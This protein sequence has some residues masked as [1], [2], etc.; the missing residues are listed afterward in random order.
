MDGLLPCDSLN[1]I[2]MMGAIVN[3]LF[4]NSKRMEAAK[5]CTH[6]QYAAGE[7]ELIARMKQMIN[8][9]NSDSTTVLVDDG[10]E[11]VGNEWD[12]PDDQYVNLATSESTSTA[13][14]ELRKFYDWNTGKTLPQMYGK[15]QLGVD[16]DAD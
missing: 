14:T 4:Q 12:D 15:K 16:Y 7:Q 3:P 5:L 9:A 8:F 11:R 1:E 10:C 2:K 6:K 13:Q